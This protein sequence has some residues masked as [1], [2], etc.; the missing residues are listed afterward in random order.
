MTDYQ[1]EQYNS[2]ELAKERQL[3]ARKKSANSLRDMRGT[4]VGHWPCRNPECRKPVEVTD[5]TMTAMATF[6]KQLR[7]GRNPPIASGEVVVCADC[8]KLLDAQRMRVQEKQRVRTK[9]AIIELKAGAIG[10]RATFLYAQL[11][12]DNHPD[13][14][15]LRSTIEEKQQGSKTKRSKGMDF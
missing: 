13:I 9:E 8:M 15:G 3:M 6:N 5:D 4:V 7:A 1:T 14:A 2:E 11:E 12:K 10:A